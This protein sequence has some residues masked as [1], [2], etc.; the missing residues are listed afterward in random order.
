MFVD[1]DYVYL[2][3]VYTVQAYRVE[4]LD[5]A[6]AQME[7]LRHSGYLAGYFRRAALFPPEHVLPEHPDT[8]L[9][10]FFLFRGRQPYM[11]PAPSRVFCPSVLP[12]HDRAHELC[13][14]TP[15]GGQAFARDLKTACEGR[16]V[17]AM[18]KGEFGAAGYYQDAF[19]EVLCLSHELTYRGA[20]ARGSA[21]AVRETLLQALGSSHALAMGCIGR[22][23]TAFHA[24]DALMVRH[25]TEDVFLCHMA[26]NGKDQA[27]ELRRLCFP[28]RAR[29]SCVTRLEQGAVFLLPE[30]L[31]RLE[32]LCRERGVDTQELARIRDHLR[33]A[34]P[35]PLPG[36]L[37]ELGFSPA[38]CWTVLPRPWAASLQAS[39]CDLN[40]VLALA[41]CMD[42]EGHLE[43]SAGPVREAPAVLGCCRQ[44]LDERN[45]LLHLDQARPLP[46]EAEA[47][48][49]IRSGA[50]YDALVVNRFA[51]VCGCTRSDL[52]FKQ[53]NRWFT[54]PDGSGLGN[55]ILRRLLLDKKMI[56]ERGVSLAQMLSIHQMYAM[57]CVH[58]AK[59]VAHCPGNH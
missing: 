26:D 40:A 24:A 28:P 48:E 18:L 20:S 2:K 30:Q 21:P 22:E 49:T 44:A 36:A 7:K 41:L 46:C 13:A 55:G 8:P 16:D 37:A 34:A 59:Q 14:V 56:E 51:V 38:N 54:P 10:K 17:F 19:E 45:D 53:G 11:R 31:T 4:E 52:V 43:V 50:W 39:G 12:L 15:A 9:L 35:L 42:A 47:D 25:G 27:A 23:E 58:G 1:Q 3:P 57:N 6:F 29:V 33:P 32:T 5:E